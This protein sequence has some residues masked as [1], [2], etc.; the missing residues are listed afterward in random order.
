MFGLDGDSSFQL[1]YLVLLLLLV[2]A[3]LRFGRGA[4]GKSLRQLGVW[5]LVGLGLVTLYAYRDPLARFAA[6]VL[7]ELDPSRVIEVTSAEGEP[8]LAVVRGGDGHFHVDATANGA[9]VNF[10]V[11]TGATTTT[12]TLR[13]A[14]RAGI[15]ITSLSFDRPV[16]TANGV[17]YYADAR[18]NELTI[19]PYKLANQSI[20]VMPEH[21]LDINLLGMNTIERFAG[22]RV[23]GDRMILTP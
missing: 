9:P 13:D 10:L 2:G 8:E 22:W 6:P 14:E 11:D 16:R 5:V 18:L 21:A 20:A 4:G 19:G 15:D 12:L 17:A 7:Q 3:G 23:E 1:I